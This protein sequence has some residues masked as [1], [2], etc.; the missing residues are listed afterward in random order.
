ML[1]YQ[2]LLGSF[3]EKLVNFLKCGNTEIDAAFVCKDQDT[4]YDKEEG[5]ARKY[6]RKWYEN[7][8][9]EAE[10]RLKNFIKRQENIPL[11]PP[12][13]V[14]LLQNKEKEQQMRYITYIISWCNSLILFIM[15]IYIIINATILYIV[16]I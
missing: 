10:K 12:G 14:L 6:A 2:I 5:L 8:K 9:R 1:Q 11:F 7:T 16:C 13:K 4:D 15:Y 3:G